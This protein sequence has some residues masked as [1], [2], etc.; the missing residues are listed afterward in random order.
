MKK[1]YLK[2][3]GFFNLLI[4]SFRIIDGQIPILMNFELIFLKKQKT[5]HS[6]IMLIIHR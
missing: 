2:I 3:V 5:F 6:Y 1:K 4:C